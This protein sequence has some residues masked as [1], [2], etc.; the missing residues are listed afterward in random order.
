M[1]EIAETLASL[2]WKEALEVIKGPGMTDREDLLSHVIYI[3][4]EVDELHG[5]NDDQAPPNT[6]I[7]E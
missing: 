5:D 4:M 7:V 6:V 1:K 2:T 3:S